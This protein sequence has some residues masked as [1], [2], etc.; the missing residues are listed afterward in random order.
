[1]YNHIS[2]EYTFLNSERLGKALAR[3]LSNP[4]SIK[5]FAASYQ[6]PGSYPEIETKTMGPPDNTL[7]DAALAL[8]RYAS[9][10][11][12]SYR[13]LI[14]KRVLNLFD[15]E[16]AFRFMMEDARARRFYADDFLRPGANRL[17]RR[18]GGDRL[19]RLSSGC[20]IPR[21]FPRDE[22][23]F[24]GGDRNCVLFRDNDP[25]QARRCPI[26]LF[27]VLRHTEL[28]LINTAPPLQCT[29]R[30]CAAARHAP[31]DL[32]LRR[33]FGNNRFASRRCAS[34]GGMCVRST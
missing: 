5:P 2:R 10:A 15:H 9:T 34:C 19:S 22:P 4:E 27:S 16:E 13:R 14:S 28:K 12:A 21:H 20:R 23:L 8:Y 3:L 18:G 1:M 17:R 31:I 33:C 30:A 24:G 11:D 25:S 32:I 29:P 6:D 26:H 7:L